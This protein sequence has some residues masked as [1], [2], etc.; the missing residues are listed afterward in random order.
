MQPLLLTID[1]F[2]TVVDWQTGLAAALASPGI[3]L[4][5]KDFERILAAQE[6]DETGPFHTY[7]EIT[8]RSLKRALGL[9]VEIGDAIG[10]DVGKWPLFP[11][12][13]EALRRLLAVTRCVAMTNSDRLHGDQVREQLGFPLTDW[14]CAEEVRLYK[15]RVEFWQKVSNRLGVA[16][17]KQW[18][19]VSAYADYDL[20]TA[21]GYGLT[22]VWV[23]RPHARRGE[24]EVR[25]KDLVEL[26]DQVEK[27][28]RP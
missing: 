2:G 25:V 21:R 12:A 17:G 10:R 9:S 7:R 11:D 19:H 24:A 6:V 22:T 1:V 28:A 3:T 18:W 26:A 14:V 16:P 23:E 15:P 4:T 8:A 27:L 13:R 20:E 5:D